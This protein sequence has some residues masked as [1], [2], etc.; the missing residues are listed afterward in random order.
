[1]ASLLAA[2]VFAQSGTAPVEG[3]AATVGSETETSSF[4]PN[5]ISNSYVISNSGFAIPKGKF[6]YQNTVL[7]INKLSYGIANWLDVSAG[8]VAYL[9]DQGNL[10]PTLGIRVTTA[11]S[12]KIR[13]AISYSFLRQTQFI[14][15]LE[16]TEYKNNFIS[17]LALATGTFGTTEKNFSL[18]IGYGRQEERTAGYTFTLAG[19]T[20]ISPKLSL[21]TDNYLR[22][23]TSYTDVYNYYGGAYNG[24]KYSGLLSAGLR[25]NFRTSALDFGLSYEYGL[26]NGAKS[27]ND[28]FPF[29]Y[30]GYRIR[31]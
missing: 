15:T 20:R 6:Q 24:S 29:P 23:W 8:F 9:G 28:E 11:V 13:L 21:T 25:M 19:I 17:T 27:N 7:L 14:N 4:R 1:M 26:G 30:A 3:T 12:R 22:N 10:S 16:G 2:P 31:F 18:G 5:L